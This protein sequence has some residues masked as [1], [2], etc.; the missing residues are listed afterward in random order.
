MTSENQPDSVNLTDL[1]LVVQII[2]ACTT[3]GAFRGEELLTVGQ[4][5]NKIEAFVKMHTPKED[6]TEENTTE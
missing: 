5:R 4:L 2:D 3:R 6:Q 1:A